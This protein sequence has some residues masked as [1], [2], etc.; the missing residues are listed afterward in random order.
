MAR[1]CS[2]VLDVS[3]LHLWII[4]CL[5]DHIPCRSRIVITHITE[6][7]MREDRALLDI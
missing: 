3:L 2:F 5:F 1:N 4:A 7:Y 6:L